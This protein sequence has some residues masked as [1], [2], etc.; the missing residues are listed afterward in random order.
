[1]VF[2]D[3]NHLLRGNVTEAKP[4]SPLASTFPAGAG[5]STHCVVATAGEAL[6]DMLVE[7][8]GRLLPCA[9]GAV[10]NLTRALGV[11]RCRDAVPE[12]AVRRPIR[13]GP[14]N[15]AAPRPRVVGTPK[16]SA[17]ADLIGYRGLG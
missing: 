11:A 8:D 14:E 16:P 12:P 6:M 1:M 17:D 4:V 3:S 13:S 2:P 10:Y 5:A 15:G 9:G 7:A